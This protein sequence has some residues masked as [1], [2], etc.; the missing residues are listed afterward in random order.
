MFTIANT[1]FIQSSILKFFVLATL[2]ISHIL[3]DEQAAC[4][5]CSRKSSVIII[6]LFNKIIAPINYIL[7]FRVRMISC[8]IQLPSGFPFPVTLEENLP[9]FS[10][11]R[12]KSLIHFAL[13]LLEITQNYWKL[14]KITIEENVYHFPCSTSSLGL[15]LPH[16]IRIYTSQSSGL[17]KNCAGTF[18]NFSLLGKICYYT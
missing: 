11:K 17:L 3:T 13:K 16:N 2:K 10:L 12:G 7:E 1:L 5:S 14:L 4:I 18:G 15:F 9:R 8:S 6:V